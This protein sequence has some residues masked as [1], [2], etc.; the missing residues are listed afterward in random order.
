[1]KYFHFSTNFRAE[2]EKNAEAE[3]MKEGWLFP[4][5]EWLPLD[6]NKRE[7]L[8]KASSTTDRART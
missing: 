8:R 4:A 7:R 3:T 1:M 5:E 6:E 2:K